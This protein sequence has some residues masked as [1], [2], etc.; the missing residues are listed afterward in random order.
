MG[1]TVLSGNI[2]ISNWS[3]YCDNNMRNG[4]HN[5]LRNSG[6]PLGLEKQEKS[7]GIFQAGKSWGILNRL[8]KSGKI[9]QNAGKLREFQ[10]N[11]IC[12]FF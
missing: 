4:S 11:F 7:E 5:R 10:K 6:F 1:C 3:N 2:H 9:T 8:E 12:Y